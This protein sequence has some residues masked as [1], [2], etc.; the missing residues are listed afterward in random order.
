M[1]L[2]MA[3][4][5]RGTYPILQERWDLRSSS[6]KR[7]MTALIVLTTNLNRKSPDLAI[8]VGI[9]NAIVGSRNPRVNLKNRARGPRCHQ[10]HE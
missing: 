4:D 10:L 1:E 7:Y 6:S 3:V 9:A 8:K 2:R 5:G